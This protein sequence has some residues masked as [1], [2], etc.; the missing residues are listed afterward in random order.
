MTVVACVLLP[1]VPVTVTVY[2]PAPTEVPTVTVS[3]DEPPAATLVGLTDAVGPAGLT[4]VVRFTV[5]AEP[6]C[7]VEMVLFPLPPTPAVNDI[8]FGFAE[9]V[10]SGVLLLTTVSATVVLCEPLVAVPVTV[11]VYVPAAA[12]VLAVNVSVELLPELMGF[13][14]NEAVTPEGTPEALRLTL[15]VEPEV[16]VVDTVTFPLDPALTL[17][18]VGET[19]IEKSFVVPHEGLTVTQAFPLGAALENSNW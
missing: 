15:S 10:K 5:P 12:L 14:L 9:I 3:V 1:S 17:R 7:V 16:I 8:E 2:V 6:T 18:L 11:T 13:G 4:D 19:L